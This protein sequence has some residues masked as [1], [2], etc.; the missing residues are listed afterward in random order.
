M[1]LTEAQ[2]C[3]VRSGDGGDI[4]VVAGPGSGKTMVLVERLRWL[5]TEGR[6]PPEHILAITFTEKAAGEMRSRLIGR[7]GGSVGQRALFETAQISTIDAFCHRLLKE[8]SIAANVDPGFEILDEDE[9]R[10]LLSSVIEETLD[11]AFTLNARDAQDFLK[12]YAPSSGSLQDDLAALVRRVRSY[13]TEPTLREPSAPVRELAEA[14]GKLAAVKKRRDLCHLRRRLEHVPASDSVNLLTL[15]TECSRA[16]RGLRAVGLAAAPLKSV[17]EELL[18]ACLAATTSAS[19]RPERKWLLGIT[20][21][22]LAGLAAAKRAAGRMDFDDLLAKTAA[23]LDSDSAPEM[24]FQHILIDEFQDTNPLQ[25][26]LVRHLVKA[27]GANRPVRFLVG[28]INQSIYG[29]RHADPTVFRKY[30]DNLKQGE[31]EV[32]LLRENFRSRPALISAVQTVLPGGGPSGVE[33][34]CLVGAKQFPDKREPSVEVQFVVDG[35][36]DP[37][38]LE[39]DWLARRLWELKSTLRVAG[40]HGTGLESRSMEWSDVAILVRN[41]RLAG[42]FASALRRH[43]IPSRSESPRGL[44]SAPETIELAGFLRVIRNPRDEISLAAILKSPF[45]GIGDADLLRL[46]GTGRNL[47]G[48][49]NVPAVLDGESARRLERFRSLLEATR[50][51]RAIV[52]ARTLLARAVSSCG[53]RSYL[54]RRP[55]SA[56]AVGNLDQLLAWIGRREE[57]RGESLNEISEALDRVLGTR[58]PPNT[59]AA[60][61]GSGTEVEVLTM[62]AA[63]G[64]E[65]PLVAVASLQASPRSN[66]PGM[67]YSPQTGI[68]ARWRSSSSYQLSPDEGYRLVAADTAR[69]EREEADRLLYVA[70]T[71]AKEHLMLSASFSGEPRQQNWCKLLFRNLLKDSQPESEA[72][73]EGRSAGEVNFRYQHLRGTPSRHDTASVA[74]TEGPQTLRPRAASAQSDYVAAVTSVTLFAQCPRRYFLERYMGLVPGSQRSHPVDR[75]HEGS[76]GRLD[77]TDASEFGTQVHLYLAEELEDPSPRV[78]NLAMRFHQHELGRRV[79]RAGTLERE[80]AFVFAVGNRLLRGTIDLLFEEG[81]ERILVD[82]KTDRVRAENARFAATRYAP[83]LQLYGVGL[84]SSGRPAAKAVVFYLRPAKPVEIEIGADA[85]AAAQDLVHRFFEAQERHEFPTHPGHQC[86]FCPYVAGLCPEPHPDR[87]TGTG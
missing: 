74:V 55:D 70:M 28:D 23:F 77:R 42:R 86:R 84:A 9:A 66:M 87:P 38:G 21:R 59:G 19:H 29:F 63:K 27:H 72:E 76:T 24:H 18:P 14:L 30:R 10:E 11:E 81:G 60:Q 54:G 36:P 43:G 25:I 26:Q 48:A 39:A 2:A 78:R 85:L 31:G 4:C 5:I 32:I 41:H 8:H 6:V 37:T 80:K 73:C 22:V 33:P 17:R 47:S 20:R 53:Y 3:A 51:D 40:Q 15:L 34:H 69:R 13:G 52:P 35:K 83:Q 56:E 44:F 16:I 82:Y 49:L 7:S 71:R 79:A 57:Q 58:L 68:G 64:L 50:A 1:K 67:V 12:A 61:S 62:H 45:C 75:A 46:K 65:F